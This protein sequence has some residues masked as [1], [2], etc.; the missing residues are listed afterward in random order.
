MTMLIAG[1]IL[2]LGMHSFAIFAPAARERFA[3]THP[4]GWK[5][6]FSL[7]SVA[8]LV[9]IIIGYGDYRLEAPLL[10]LPPEGLRHVAALLLLP[11]FILFIAPYFPSRINQTIGHPQLT[12]V[13]LWAT[14]HLLANGS[15]ADVILFGAFLA[16]AV[17]DRISLKRRP[18]RPVPR[19]SANA[20]ANLVIVITAGLALYAAFILGLHQWLIGVPPLG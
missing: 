18:R 5:G 13:K 2:F 9:L 12:A 1:L 14:A 16:W 15:L 6:F 17:A 3:A 7:V 4:G 8:G 10:Y 20:R 19:V 11:V